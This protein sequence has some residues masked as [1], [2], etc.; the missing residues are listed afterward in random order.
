MQS[1][2]IYAHAHNL[3]SV[4]L[5]IL[6]KSA[7]KRRFFASYTKSR[8]LKLFLATN[9]RPE[10][11]LM[12]LMRMRR[13]YRHESRRKWGRALIELEGLSRLQPEADVPPSCVCVIM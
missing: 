8:S 1:E 10:V 4:Y 9:M 5:T 6:L 12:Y 7:L 11:E 3:T 2:V 13:H